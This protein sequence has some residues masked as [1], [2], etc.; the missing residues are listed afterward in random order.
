MR[1]ILTAAAL[2]ATFAVTAANAEPTF[3]QGGPVRVGNMCNI[4][5][6]GGDS[7]YGYIGPCP[8]AAP[9]QRKKGKANRG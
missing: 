2:A 4:E 6:N 5:T 8:Q 3:V 7:M 9:I 1:Y